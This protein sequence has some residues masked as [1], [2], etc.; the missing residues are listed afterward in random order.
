MSSFVLE[1]VSFA[2][3]VAVTKYITIRHNIAFVL[4]LDEPK[5]IKYL[6]TNKSNVSYITNIIDQFVLIFYILLPRNSSF[7]L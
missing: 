3:V 5:N 2:K 7:W 1:Q 6:E 4:F